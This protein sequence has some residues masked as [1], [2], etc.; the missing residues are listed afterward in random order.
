M[1]K[2]KGTVGRLP[3]DHERWHQFTGMVCAGASRNEIRRT[4][5]LDHRTIDMYLEDYD[6]HPVGGG[7]EAAVIRE[8]NRRLREFERRGKI[9]SDRDSGF[10]TR[11]RM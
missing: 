9:G 5:G 8:T 6:V 4:M 2:R 11:G 1:A 10:N 7:G 3:R